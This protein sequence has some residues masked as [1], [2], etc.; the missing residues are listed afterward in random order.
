MT[1]FSINQ[2]PMTIYRGYEVYRN[3]LTKQFYAYPLNDMTT[4]RKLTASTPDALKAAIDE[5]ST[6]QRLDPW[7]LP[8]AAAETSI[9]A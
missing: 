9:A 8:Y 1:P 2:I 3:R 6:E 7:E 4:D 5:A